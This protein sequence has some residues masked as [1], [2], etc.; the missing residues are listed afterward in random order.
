MS[1]LARKCTSSSTNLPVFRIPF[2]VHTCDDDYPLIKD[3]V[4]DCVRKPVKERTAR[5]AV[6]NRKPIWILDDGVKKRSYFI[7]KLIAET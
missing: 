3:T 4:E 6:N 2:T 1:F 7:Q 5:I